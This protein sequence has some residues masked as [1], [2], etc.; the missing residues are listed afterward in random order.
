M[1]TPSRRPLRL[2]DDVQWPFDRVSFGAKRKCND[3]STRVYKGVVWWGGAGA[4]YVKRSVVI[5]LKINFWFFGIDDRVEIGKFVRCTQKSDNI[6]IRVTGKSGW[7]PD[8]NRYRAGRNA[9]AEHLERFSKHPI[10]GFITYC[11]AR[12]ARHAERATCWYV[13]YD[14]ERIAWNAHDKT[15]KT[16][17]RV[18]NYIF[19]NVLFFKRSKRL[20]EQR[21]YTTTVC[22]YFTSSPSS[23]WAGSM[24]PGL[25]GLWPRDTTCSVIVG[26]QTWGT[27]LPSND[28]YAAVYE[29]CFEIICLLIS[30]SVYAMTSNADCRPSILSR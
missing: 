9:S 8:G 10:G 14:T 15:S 26:W 28:D 1:V 4:H 19:G 30:I 7:S 12:D 29:C 22:S 18:S 11:W 21:S 25:G 13:R 16:Y 24:V 3:T 6:L 5:N 23:S 17:A 20:P 2:S 27:V